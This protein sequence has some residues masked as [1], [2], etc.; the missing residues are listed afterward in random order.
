M[1]MES[2]TITDVISA[3]SLSSEQSKKIEAILAQF[4]ALS[5]EEKQTSVSETIK[6]VFPLV[7]GDSAAVEPSAH[8][9]GLRTSIW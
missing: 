2:P 3:A 9:E 5:P 1:T 6:T 7:F 8:Y 4:S